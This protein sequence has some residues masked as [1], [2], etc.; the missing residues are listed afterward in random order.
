MASTYIAPCTPAPTA[1]FLV[2][3]ETCV[4]MG[5]GF[6]YTSLEHVSWVYTTYTAPVGLGA[7][8]FQLGTLANLSWS[9]KPAF[10]PVESYNIGDD[11]IWDVTGE[12]TMLTIELQQLDPRVLEAAVG[13]GTMYTIGVERL[14]T[15]G[16][17]CQIRSRPFSLEFVNDSCNAPSA[18][19][20]SA[21]ITG[22]CL[23]LYDC[24]VQSGLEWAM[25]A[26]ENNTIPLELQARP[27]LTQ[28]RGNRLGNL[29]L[30]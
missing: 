30:Y 15:F 23:T 2:K 17:G 22:G 29:Y 8:S 18:Q 13:T 11:S 12:E 10:E 25:A 28:S 1:A 14:I 27:V 9:H 4:K 24:F 16:G 20:A 7:A 21:G 19:D 6:L 5:T 26:K 3:P